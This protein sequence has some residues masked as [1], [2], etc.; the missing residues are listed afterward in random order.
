M[1]TR[2]EGNSVNSKT[3]KPRYQTAVMTA[4]VGC[5]FSLIVLVLL[6]FNYVRRTGV[7]ARRIDEL[8]RLKI[9]ILEQPTDEELKSQI[10]EL[11][12]RVRQDRIRRLDFSRNG[13]YLLLG[14]VAVFLIGVKCACA[15]RKKLPSPQ[16]KGDS[17]N[18]QICEARRGRWAV[19][20]G[21]V[22]LVAGAI[23]LASRPS[24]DL[25][26]VGTVGTSY[27]SAEEIGKNWPRFRGPGGLG[28]SAYTNVPTNWNG[29]TREGILWKK[30]VP[31]PGHSSPVFWGDRVFV[32][33]GNKDKREVYCFDAVSG[34]QLWQGSVECVEGSSSVEV[35]V[36]E[37]TGFAAPTAVTDGR[38][39]YA[40]FANGDVGCFDVKGKKVWTINLGVPDSTYGYASSPAM[41]RNLLLIQ[42]DQGNVEDEKSRLIALSVFS[43]QIVW[44]T[45]RPVPNSW[46]SPIV[47]KVGNQ[48]QIITC[49]DPWVIAYDP[50]NGAEIWRVGC[51]GTDVA[52]SA[53]YAGGLV[54]ATEPY[55]KLVAIR[56]DGQGDVTETHIAWSVEHDAP[57]ICSPVSN[58]ELFFS[59]TTF[60]TLSCY[61][62][63]DGTPLW[64]KDLE[65]TFRA[66]PSIVGSRVYLLSERGV[67]IIIEVGDEYRELARCELGEACYASPAFADGRI[68]IRGVENLY[69]IG[70]RPSEDP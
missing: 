8:D 18:E 61:K 25:G 21:L 59:L 52:P 63:A 45:Q 69:C 50:S 56:Q 10:R 67:T 17:R 53:I 65:G 36:D 62:V 23:L 2:V 4:V 19:T 51:L 41:Y 14:G 37:A 34:K 49:G 46:T 7:D 48:H 60:G 68:Y 57:D 35:K 20:A 33:G 47:I 26:R 55:T 15:F 12:L 3:M 13:I 39:V 6:V 5:V 66:S 30:K 11:D 43:G 44:Q 31:L 42:Y 32:S 16:S 1:K 54:F 22:V 58:G 24:I 9:E 40:I 38:R 29:K 28:I 70:T 27:P 64:E